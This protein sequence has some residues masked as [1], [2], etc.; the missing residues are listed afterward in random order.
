MSTSPSRRRCDLLPVEL[1]WLAVLNPFVH[2]VGDDAHDDAHTTATADFQR[3]GAAAG[4]VGSAL[5]S[6]EA[7]L[8]A[9]GEAC[10]ERREACRRE[11]VRVS[12]SRAVAGKA[13]GTHAS[14]TMLVAFL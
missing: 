10:A 2:P 13:T 4:T 5:A 6:L 1:L 11:G 12:V 7:N 14:S 8:E 9:R 3:D